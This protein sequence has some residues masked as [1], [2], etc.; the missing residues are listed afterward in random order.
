MLYDLKHTRRKL[1]VA[2]ER[3]WRRFLE[4]ISSKLQPK[5]CENMILRIPHD[6]DRDPGYTSDLK[7]MVILYPYTPSLWDTL[8]L[9]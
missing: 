8:R 7:G 2:L 9:Y 4:A 6:T 3:A 1:N 5:F